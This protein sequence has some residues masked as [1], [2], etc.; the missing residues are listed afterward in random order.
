MSSTSQHSTA[1]GPT[2]SRSPAPPA[3]DPMKPNYS[4]FSGFGISQPSSQ[5]TT[6]APSLFQQQQA[7]ATA[8]QQP[9]SDPF[10]SITGPLRQSTPQQSQSSASASLFDFAQ[11]PAPAPA[12]A[13]DDDEW[14]FSSALP[15][16]NG[17]P[18]STDIT[19]TDST[20]NIT[21]HATRQS[22]ADP[23]ITMTVKFSNKSPQHI[24]ELT[25]QVAVTKVCCQ[26]S[27]YIIINS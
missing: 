10:A 6:P 14:N 3:V 17:L 2:P 23:V 13:N 26:V 16:S 11:P 22:P 9:P 19:I 21:L 8:S 12:P 20:I 5:S 15:E 4:P 7:A 1:R 18:S 25:F 24:S 27:C